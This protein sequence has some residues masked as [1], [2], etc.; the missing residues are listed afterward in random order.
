IHERRGVAG[1]GHRHLHLSAAVTRLWCDLERARCCGE[2]DRDPARR[3]ATRLR[4]DQ[5]GECQNAGGSSKHA[6]RPTR[7]SSQATRPSSGV[8]TSPYDPH[9]TC[10]PGCPASTTKL[11]RVL[12]VPPG[13]STR[14]ATR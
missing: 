11:A 12:T 13:V 14:S 4:S 10:T 9:A 6:A 1:V 5:T 2:L 8:E 3:A 7:P